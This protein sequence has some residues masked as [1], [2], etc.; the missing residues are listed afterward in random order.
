[1]ALTGAGIA[2]VSVGALF[3]FSAN[4]D[5]RA[6]NGANHY[7]EFDDKSKAS[8]Q[9]RTIAIVSGAVGVTLGALGVT[10]F[11]TRGGSTEAVAE[12]TQS[13]GMLGVRSAF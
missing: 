8:K 5:A 9:K 10:R 1:M 3:W 11:L 4:S 7:G 2:G 12:V 13:G 6:A